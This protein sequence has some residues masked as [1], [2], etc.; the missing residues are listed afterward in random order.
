M[1]RSCVPRTIPSRCAWAIIGPIEWVS[2]MTRQPSSVLRMAPGD[3]RNLE[4]E[5]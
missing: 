2:V 1:G 4:T 3:G 5:L